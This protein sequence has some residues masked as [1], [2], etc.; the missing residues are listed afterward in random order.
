MCKG[1]N[2]MQTACILTGIKLSTSLPCELL[3]SQQYKTLHPIFA[4]STSELLALRFSIAELSAIECALVLLATVKACGLLSE[5]QQAPIERTFFKTPKGLLAPTLEKALDTLDAIRSLP[6]K[7][8]ESI[9]LTKCVLAG[10]NFATLKGVITELAYSLDFISRKKNTA[11]SL[12]ALQS[13]AAKTFMETLEEDEQWELAD[14]LVSKVPQL[15]KQINTIKAFNNPSTCIN[16]EAVAE[17]SLAIVEVVP[18][19]EK[20]C[21]EELGLIY[22]FKKVLEKKT[23]VKV[24]GNWIGTIRYYTGTF[25]APSILA[26]AKKPTALDAMRARVKAASLKDLKQEVSLEDI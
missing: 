19:I 5:N 25:V 24:E 6:P 21:L 13:N 17:V 16:K 22:L 3:S 15:E 11:I 12:E 26:T 7:K 9:Q 4:L 20:E 10:C 8:A 23:N 14:I 1:L 18:A 2:S